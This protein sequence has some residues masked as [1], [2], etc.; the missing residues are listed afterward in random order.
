MEETMT[1]C[2]VVDDDPEI[3]SSLCSY[4]QSYGLQAQAAADGAVMRRLVQ[5]GGADLVLL[6]LMLPG[7]DGLSLL[8]WL[9]Q[10]HPNLPVI[11]LTARGDPMSR[12]VGLELG[13]DDYVAKPFE[14]RELIARIQ[15]VLRRG[16]RG[17]AAAARVVR[18]AGWRFDRVARQL[19]TAADVTVPLSGAEFRLL[20]AFVDNPGRVLSRERLLE[21]TRAPGVDVNDRSI[22]LA[23]SRLRAKLGDTSREATL[24]R[25]VRGEGYLFDVEVQ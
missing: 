22:D 7:E 19:L 9:Q 25:T 14:P 18:F 11:M 8:R 4:L 5:A 3:R 20:S 17:G 6:D 10:Q 15:A 13:A 24:L 23:V 1:R 16:Q 2:L 21:L 12:V